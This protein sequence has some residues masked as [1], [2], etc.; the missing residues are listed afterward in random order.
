[1]TE[2]LPLACRLGGFDTATAQRYQELRAAMKAAALARQELPDG[3]GFRF[4]SE[5]RIFTQLAEWV[6]LER[7]CCP[8][9]SFALEWSGPDDLWLRLTGGPDVKEF[10]R[11]HLTV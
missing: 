11:D 2:P 9:F 3:Y 4:V 6:T 8:F 5:A 7:V 1:M 10:L